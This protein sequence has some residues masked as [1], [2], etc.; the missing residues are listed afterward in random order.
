MIWG[1]HAGF[2]RQL[3]EVYFFLKE[4]PSMHEFSYQ[5]KVSKE[6]KFDL[7]MYNDSRVWQAWINWFRLEDLDELFRKT[8]E[9]F[10][11]PK[12]FGGINVWGFKEIRYGPNDRVF[13]FLN[14]L[15]PEANY[16]F[17]TRD[18]LNTIESQITTFHQGISKF[19]KLKRLVKLPQLLRIARKWQ[20]QN[21]YYFKLSR[22]HPETH[23]LIRYED[24]LENLTILNPI[25]EK[26]GL[27]IGDE[28]LN[29]LSMKEG[30]GTNFQLNKSVHSRWMRMGLI[31]AFFAEIIVGATSQDLEYARPAKL[32][33]AT[34]ISNWLARRKPSQSRTIM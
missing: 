17:I 15:Y 6:N 28:Q 27:E 33:L 7:S 34:Y 3:S 26:Y 4:N 22:E 10:F 30:R 24:V 29:V 19:T 9:N 8:V 25:L 23:Y 5:H 2:L 20:V 21:A 13:D 31:P 16:I 1:E 32:S 14:H 12:A 18:S 11:C